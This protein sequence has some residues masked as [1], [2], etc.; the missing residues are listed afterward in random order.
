MSFALEAE[1]DVRDIVVEATQ[2]AG[3]EASISG[4]SL[5]VHVVHVWDQAGVGVYRGPR[6][7]VPELLLKDDRAR[8]RDG[9]TRR[10]GVASHLHRS[11][12]RYSPPAVRLDGAVRT[13]LAAAAAKQLWVTV[14]T[15]AGVPAGTYRGHLRIARGQSE[16]TRLGI[17]VE[18]L[19]LELAEPEQDLMLWYLGTLDCR[20]PQHYVVPDVFEA[21]LRDIYATGFRSLSLF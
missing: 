21:Q 7:R 6:M 16:L 18:V 20:R 1:R 2:L 10:C 19:P 15:P 8:L 3:A 14:R 11:R 13:D 5:D 17:E 4:D 9:Y 12:N